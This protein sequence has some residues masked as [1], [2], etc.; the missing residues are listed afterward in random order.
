LNEI[1]EITKNHK[2]FFLNVLIMYDG[3]SEIADAA[4]KMLKDHIKPKDVDRNMI[5]EYLY[6]KGMPEV[7]YIIRT[8]MNDGARI[9]GFLLWDSSY[10][11]FRFRK[12][13]WPEYNKE[14]LYEDLVEYIER[15]RRKGS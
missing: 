2:K 12:D 7:D 8:G 15:N 5:K 9:S 3:Q 14:M 13:F 10:A 11:E 1:E 4:R 6:T